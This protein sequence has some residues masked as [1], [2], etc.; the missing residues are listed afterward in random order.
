M[1]P[2]NVYP[3]F[4]IL[5]RTKELS[6]LRHTSQAV[7]QSIPTHTINVDILVHN[8]ANTFSFI[9]DTEKEEK[10]ISMKVR[11]CEAMNLE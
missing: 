7:G 5:A 8:N 10:V 3:V 1:C 2:S 9:D 6:P 11:K 4:I